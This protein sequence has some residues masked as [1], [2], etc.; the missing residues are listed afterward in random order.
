MMSHEMLGLEWGPYATHTFHACQVLIQ[1]MSVTE[2]ESMQ[3][4]TARQG[5]DRQKTGGA[6]ILLNSH[7]M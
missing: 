7:L 4:P 1:F 3:F 5:V 6:V 2:F